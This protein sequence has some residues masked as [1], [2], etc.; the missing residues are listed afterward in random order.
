M[1]FTDDDFKRWKET[2]GDNARPLYFVYMSEPTV[3]A[4]LSRL[5]AAEAAIFWENSW[6]RDRQITAWQKAAGK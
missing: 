5:E 2:I 1:T 4:I 6:D 3:K